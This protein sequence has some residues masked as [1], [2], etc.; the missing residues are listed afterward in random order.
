MPGP[1]SDDPS[2]HWEKLSQAVTHLSTGDG[3][4]RERLSAFDKHLP[5]L[6]N[7]DESDFGGKN[8]Q[9]WEQTWEVLDGVENAPK[10]DL[11]KAAN[12]ILRLYKNKVIQRTLKDLKGESIPEDPETDWA[13]LARKFELHE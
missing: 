1:G 13:S 7:L 2:Y 10:H 12:N 3:D 4:L 5:Q 6:G 9:L 11:E 8:K